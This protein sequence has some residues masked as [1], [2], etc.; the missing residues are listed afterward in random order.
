MDLLTTQGIKLAPKDT[1]EDIAV[2]RA[3]VIGPLLTRAFTSHGELADAIRVLAHHKHLPPGASV[4]R[5]YSKATLE[6]WYYRFKRRGLQTTSN[7]PKPWRPSTKTAS[8][9][10][11]PKS[12]SHLARA[13]CDELLPWLKQWHNDPSEEFGGLKLGDYFEGYV[14]G[15]ERG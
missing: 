7:K 15:E 13:L 4:T 1:A 9:R 10:V 8:A 14:E 3:Q 2:F 6:R 12:A 11:G 5:F